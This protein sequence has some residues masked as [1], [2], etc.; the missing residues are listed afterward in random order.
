[1]SEAAASLAGAVAPLRAAQYDWSAAGVQAALAACFH[2]D[3][4]IRLCHPFGTLAGPESFYRS[5]LAPLA[6]A[7]PDLERRDWIVMEGTDEDGAAWVGCGGSYMGTFA[8]PFL[9]IP[10][11]G[12]LA[13]MRFHE[14]Y[15]IEAGRVV[16]V[17]AIWDIPE[18]MMQAGSWPLAPSLGREF[19]V[20]GPASG[21]GLHRAPRDE[22][23]SAASCALV[24]DMLTHMTRH[25]AQGGP[26]VMEMPRFWH[27]RMNWY[28]PA[29][30]GTARGIEGFRTVHQIPFLAAM[31]DRAQNP[32]GTKHHFFADNH[33]VAVTGWP[34][35]AQTITGGGWLGIAPTGQRVTLRSLDFWRI[36]ARRIRENW[37]LVDLLDLYDQIG[38]D[39][40]AR[41]RELTHGR[42]PGSAPAMMEPV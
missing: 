18:L 31:P 23:T 4:V 30:I 3:A 19:C 6:A 40:F 22:A 32:E 21:D 2:P 14:F 11:T 8:A 9:G 33:Y 12:R 20:P 1:M 17:Q 29:G 24:I 41:L 25:P 10:P 34:N 42:H 13:H 15:R 16:E 37:V 7:L 26:E 27:E 28:G 5:A 39:V 35:M 36:E 38:V